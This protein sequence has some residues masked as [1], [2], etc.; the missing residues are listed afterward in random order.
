MD[1]IRK[2]EGLKGNEKIEEYIGMLQKEPSAEMLS[3]TLTTIRRRMREGGQ[4]IVPVDMG[5]GSR[6]QIQVM[7]HDGASWL[8]AFTGFE[9]ELKGKTAVMS[10][11]MADIGQI[12]DMALSGDVAGVILNPWD[13]T[14]RLDRN[15]IRIIKGTAEY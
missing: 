5:K 7:Q 12:F 15:L 11:F 13:K 4:F 2:D 6:L 14:M 8:P 3:V 10:T 9:E 1:E